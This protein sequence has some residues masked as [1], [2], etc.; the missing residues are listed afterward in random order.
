MTCKVH[1]FPKGAVVHILLVC[2][3]LPKGRGH[4]LSTKKCLTDCLT[5]RPDGPRSGLSVVAAQ[6][7]HACAESVRV[8]DF[9]R[10]LLAKHV[11]LTR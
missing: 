6:T 3:P 10:E 4:M 7:I 2:Q 8:P 1:C 5:L 9:L 11:R